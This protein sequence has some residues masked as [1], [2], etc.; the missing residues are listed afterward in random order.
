[1]HASPVRR[2]LKAALASV[3]AIVMGVSAATLVA[4]AA[5]AEAAVVSPMTNAYNSVVNGNYLM[6]GNGVMQAGTSYLTGGTADAFHN[7]VA[8]T[9]LVNDNFQMQRRNAVPALQAAG[10]D[11]STSATLTVPSGASIARAYLFWQ[12]STGLAGNGSGGTVQRCNASVTPDATLAA[13]SPANRQVMLQVGSGAIS[14]VAGAVTIE[15]TPTGTL[16][17]YYSAFADVTSQLS[18]IATGSSQTI[19]VGNLWAAEGRNCYAGWSLALVYDFGRFIPGNDASQA[20]NV[21]IA[22]GHV[23]LG[24]NESQH[25]TF[26]GFTSAAGDIQS[27][28]FLGEGDRN[29][30]G[31]YAQYR[32][33][34][35]GAFTRIAGATGETDNVG[36]GRATGSVRFQGTST[37][38]FFNGSVD[39]RTTALTGIPVGTSSIQLELGTVQDTYML[40]AAALAV[41]VAAVRIEKTFTGSGSTAVDVQDILPG[42]APSYTITVTNAGSSPVSNVQVADTLAPSCV[43]T[44]GTLAVGGVTQYT[45]TG[46]ATNTGL[47]NTATVSGTGIISDSD[48]TVVN[49]GAISLAKTVTPS[50]GYTG[51]PGDTLSY[52]FTIRNSG[53]SELRGVTLTD[54]MSGL[55]GLA[56]DWGTSSVASTPPGTLAAGE[57]VI[58][59]ATYALTVT[60]VDRGTVTNPNA[61]ARGL[62]PNQV[63]VTSTASATQTIPPAP[64]L[65]LSKTGTLAQGA[66]GRVG[67]L[68]T[69]SFSA[70]N[71]GNVTLSGVTITDPH[72]GLS[73]IVY[74]WPGTA[75]VLRA[76]QTV[77]ATATAPI[78]QAE[79]DAGRVVN[80]ARVAGTSPTNVAVNGTATTTVAITQTPTIAIDKNGTL[81]TGAGAAGT[82]VNYTF[83]VVNTGNV[84]LT[85]I[86]VSDPN[87]ASITPPS[88]WT[89]T[90]APGATARFTA[91]HTITQTEV[92]A[93][94]V[95]NT[96]T[97]RGTPP[98]GAA[99]TG[100]D[101]FVQ[102]LANTPGI[103]LEKT[104]AHELNGPGNA[105]DTILYTFA[106]R[107]TGQSTLT[108]ITISDPM[109]AGRQPVAQTWPAATGTLQ[110]GQ[111]ASV[112]YRMPI[113]QA[114][115]DAGYVDNTA[116][117]TGTAQAG[118]VTDSDTHRTPINRTTSVLLSKTVTAPT[119]TPQVGTQLP[120]RFVIAN[121]GSTTLTNVALSDPMFTQA[122]LTYAWPGTP[123]TLAPGAQVVVTASTALTQAQIDAGT[124]GN[125][126]TATA[127]G[128]SGVPSVSSTSHADAAIPRTPALSLTKTGAIAT[129]QVGRVGDTIQYELT[130]VNTGNVTLTNVTASDAMPGLV[131]PTV[132]SWPRSTPGTLLPGDQV[133]FTATYVIRASDVAAGAV[134][135]SASATG[136]GPIGGT[137]IATA[138][139]TVPLPA[140]T[141]VAQPDT[142][143]TTQGAPGRVLPLANDVPGDPGVPLIP[144][145]LTLVDGAGLAVTS[146]TLPGVG[147]FTVDRST[148]GSPAVVFTPVPGFTGQAP[149]VGYRVNDA[150]GTATS[151]TIVATVTPVTPTAQP[152][153][154]TGRQGAPASVD[155]LANDAPGSASIPLQRSSVSYVNGAGQPVATVTVDGQGTWS[156]NR[157]DPQNPRFVFTPLPSFSGT[158]T[159][160][161]YR[162]LDA[163]GT[164]AT[165]TV[166]AQITAVAPALQPDTGSN[167]QGASVTVA[168]FAND[169]PGDPAVPLQP[170]TITLVGADGQGTNT[171]TIAGQGT[172]TLVRTDPAVPRIV[173]TPIAPF[174]GE[175]TPVTYQVSDANGVPARTTFTPTITPVAPI[176]RADVGEARQGATVTIDPFVNDEPG[177]AAVPIVRSQLTLLDAAGNPTDEIV[178]AGQGTWRVVRTDAASP[179]ITFTPLPAFTGQATPQP[180]RIADANGT[181]AR[182]TVGA[183]IGAVVPIASPDTATGRQGA[184]ASVDPLANDRPGDPAVPLVPSTLQLVDGTGTVVP[185]IVV[186]N[187][188]T[189]TVDRTNPDAPRLVFT[190]LPGFTGASTPVAYQVADANGT[191]ASSTVRA[192][193]SAV[194]PIANPDTA[195]GRQGAA[196]PFDVVA[197]DTPG[198]P[199]VPIDRS[200]L[201]LVGAD[202]QGGVTIADQGRYTV[203][204]TNTAAPFVVFTPLLPFTGTATP[205]TYQVADAN[206]TTAQS[207]YTPTLTPVTPVANPDT[208]ATRQGA[209]TTIDPLA[210]DRPGDPAVPL[211]PGSLTLIGAGGQPTDTITVPGQGTWTVDRTG[212]T[213]VVTFTPEPGFSGTADPVTYQVD[214]QNGTPVRSTITVTVA[215]VTPAA[216]PDSASGRQGSQVSAAVLAND[217]AGD[218]AVPLVPSTLTL[219]T[220]AGAPA[221]TVT[222]TGQGTY[223]IDAITDPAAPR[224][225]FT[226]LAS[227]VGTATPVDYRV[228]D[229]NRT[230]ARST[231][232]PTLVGVT[233]VATDDGGAARQGA[234][235]TVLPLANDRPGD[236][237]VPL[238]PATITLLDAAGAAATTVTFDG[239]GTYTLDTTTTP[240]TPRIVFQPVLLFDGDAT[241]VR[242][243][244]TDANGTPATA[245]VRPV[246]A[247]VR[248][249]AAPDAASGLQGSPVSAAVLD[250]DSPG[251]GEVPLVPA[252]L[253][254]LLGDEVVPFVDVTGGRYTIDRGAAGGPRIVFTP[255]ASF[256]G[257]A[258]PV[259]YRVADANT[260]TA[261]STFTP[262]LIGVEP[263]AL[264]DEG[265]GHQGER[266]TLRPLANDSSGDPSVPLVPATFTLLNA[267]GDRVDTLLVPNE[268]LWTTDRTDPL[269]PTVTFAPIGSFT[270]PTTPVR[271]VVADENGTE[272]EAT[273]VV[274]TLTP[275]T[276]V[277]NP[278]A[279]SGR[280]GAPVSAPVVANDAQGHPDVPL[281]PSSL[282]LVDAAGALVPVGGTVTLD[283]TQGT[284]SIDATTDPANPTIV[285]TPVATYANAAE[286]ATRVRYSIAD[287]NGTRAESTFTPTITPVTPVANPDEGTNHQ[288]APVTVSPLAN[289]APGLADV[290]LQPETLTLLDADGNP[291]T[292]VTTTQGR[293][294][295]DTTTEPGVPHIVFTPLLSYVGTALPVT[296]R[297]SDANGTPDTATFTPTLTPVAPTASPDSGTGRQGAPVTIHPLVNDVAGDPAVPLVPTSLTLVG[298][299]GGSVDELVV[300]DQGTWRVDRTTDPANPVIVFEPLPTFRGN[301]TPVP[302]RVSDANGTPVASAISVTI[303]PVDPVLQ[304]DAG[305]A[306]QGATVTLA[307][308]ANDAPGDAGVPLVPSTFT[309]LDAAGNPVAERTVPNEGTYRVDATDPA[310]PL[311][312]FTPL[313]TFR[314]EATPVSYRVADANGTTATSTITPTITGVDPVAQ[315]DA[316]EGRQGA[317]VT[318]DALAN[319]MAGSPEVPLVRPSLTLLDAVGDA[320]DTRVIAGQGTWTVV[321]TDAANPVL[322]FTPELGFVGESTV[323]YAVLDANGTRAP[324]TATATITAVTP[325]ATSDVA[326]SRQGAPA[327]VAPLANDTA[328]DPDVPL[329]PS[330]LTL[331]DGDGNPVAEIVIPG[332]GTYTID[333]STPAAPRIV[334]TPELTFVGPATPAPYRVLDANG[335]PAQSLVLPI[336]EPVTPLANPDAE[337]AR[338]G[339]VITFRP[340]GNDTQGHPDVPFAPATL[341][342]LD[343]DG[344]PVDTL[345]VPGQ[346]TYAVDRSTPSNPT[347]TFTPELSFVGTASPAT[348]RVA[349][350]NGTTTTSTITPTLV[351]V[352]P[353]ANPDA[354]SGRQGSVVSAAVLANDAA[355]TPSV[356]LVPSTLT[357]IDA[358]GNA[359]TTVTVADQGT[360]SID[361]STAS[362]P[363]IA[364]T[365]LATYVGIATPVTYQVADANGTGAR[366]TF[367]PTLVGVT[368]VALDDAGSARQGATVTVLPL[369]NDSAGDASVPLDPSTFMLLDGAGNPVPS[370]TVPLQ[371]VYT[372]AGT[373]TAPQ[374]VFTPFPF[375]T[376]EATPAPYRVADAN[377][378]TATAF[379][380]PTIAGVEPVA[381]PDFASGR[382]GAPVSAAVLDNDSPGE[383]DVPLEP[384]TLTLLQGD[385][386]VATVDVPGG[387]YSIDRTDA[388][389]PRIVF[390]PD[391]AFVGTAE[392]VAYLVEDE[393]GTEA[394][395]TFTPTLVPVTPIADPDAAS[396]RQGAPVSAAV[397]A[398]DDAGHPDVPLDPTTLQLLD[399]S[400]AVATVVEVPGQG[401]Y[402]IDASD[403]DAPRIV[404]TPLPGYVGTA[405]PVT[406]RVADANGT[407]TES[408]FTPTLV[409]VAPIASPDFAS[410][411]QGAAV[412][413]PV[414]ANDDA[415]DDDVPLVPSTLRLLDA[416]GALTTQVDVP[417]QGTY[418]IDVSDADAPRIVFTPLPDFSGQ[419]TAVGYQVS[420]ANGTH[421]QSTFTPT[422]TAVTPIAAPD[423]ATGRQGSPVSSPVLVNDEA[424]DDEV[425]L[426]PATLTL[427]DADGNPVESVTIV[428]EGTY[429]VDASAP[430]SPR[431]VFTPLADYVG[432]AVPVAYRISDAN[433]TPA[434][435]TFTPTLVEVLPIASPDS[436]QA[437]QGKTVTLDA[438][439]NDAAGSADVP[440]V[441]STL[442]LRNGAGE[443]VDELVLDGVGT[444]TVDRTNPDRP[445]LVF[446]P[447]PGYVGTSTVP[448][449]VADAN[450]TLAPTTA[451]ATI[452]AVTPVATD[453][454]S[455]GP[456]GETQTIDP[457]ANDRAGDPSVPLDP[458]TLVLLDESGE[459]VLTR[460]VPGE[461]TY[462]VVDG[463]I[464]FTPEAGFVGTATGV[465]YRVADANGTT[466]Q[467]V[468]TPRVVDGPV[469]EVEDLYGEGMRGTPVTVDP[470]SGEPNLDPTS[471]RLVDASGAQ[472]GAIVVPGEGT[473]TVDPVTGFITFTPEAGL[474]GDPTP[475][476]WIGATTDG[477]IVTG[478]VVVHYLDPVSPPPTVDPTGSTPPTAP[479]PSGP[480]GPGGP[481]LPRTGVEPAGWLLVLAAMLGLVGFGLLRRRR[482]SD[483]L[484]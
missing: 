275:V 304:P 86:T 81:A 480:G 89:G 285:F 187:Q 352:T 49:V 193:I 102:P 278:D 376:G 251:N 403:E 222:I 211:R 450:G 223:S 409:A 206:G 150:N 135:N 228:E 57:T 252:S 484:V 377:G 106:I 9:G 124:V 209:S 69:Y 140:A 118:T 437:L 306:R 208:G 316:G 424:G 400:G 329:V 299:G 143:S 392:P 41:P 248:P 373:A 58:G 204:R 38:T 142:I 157:D 267:A 96:A 225:V 191:I 271:Y 464:A 60:D 334:F 149:A 430:A 365:P 269:N 346:G 463:R 226:P 76:G 390:T 249:A 449:T 18:T 94:R 451:S 219:L 467:A 344:T 363:R 109:L 117:A 321:R 51:R 429:R 391:A 203:D 100:T 402:A 202:A 31:D 310:N 190:P 110:P 221:T 436:G 443:P 474:E 166:T 385:D 273:V 85:G 359:A 22:N 264:P 303:T 371:G 284:Y 239:V 357:L 181:T 261:T 374:V 322:A 240:G 224:I 413:S 380:R 245:F 348:Y 184:P 478:Q 260:E 292:E 19:N 404:F 268:G 389:N 410:G 52:T 183:T 330:T 349:D 75:G 313:L 401:S 335:T 70:T 131:G 397:L 255:D 414:L 281:V 115:I 171:V 215:A 327:S 145:T 177:N 188:G 360:Y 185:Q 305:E 88:G 56:I 394:R 164:A 34:T 432:T 347:V 309:L 107:N 198:D 286:P 105:D 87:V 71:T 23:R 197:N 8:L 132:V 470:S 99:V 42:Q 10:A 72:V 243:R 4:P 43:R 396:G 67:D 263:V 207:T 457:L 433:G 103:D 440:L 156:V 445:V 405:T 353:I 319:D 406:Y 342:L 293:Y 372:V 323:P 30:S 439:A 468:Y 189:W 242:Y 121:N 163:N 237:A 434:E 165:S 230:T 20:R 65:N 79:I 291:A 381:S 53:S 25:T 420:D 152:D 37:D 343:A 326:T 332:Q 129:G 68:V 114:Q 311:V 425:P 270:G 174:T 320:V 173:F 5:P 233:P 232:T 479:A 1:M 476:R 95:S 83:D 259:T 91:S 447:L 398:N 161:P 155:P 11:N 337:S 146:I 141:P 33:G 388:A 101:T 126:A 213:P 170:G 364:F 45:C 453:D 399:G 345:T 74:T 462:V 28:F 272:T 234:P 338:Q 119:G 288:G 473:W 298:A 442:T 90:L 340:L 40:Q 483:E 148:V 112:Q 98:T 36:T 301:A 295:L 356:P 147:T 127:T 168:P 350:A 283:A 78:T 116:S 422:I 369:A 279:A 205:V 431:I 216:V 178:V 158:S 274:V 375:F 50:N 26:S 361:R 84:T 159:A 253:E 367:T 176:A 200:S 133:R 144:S 324:S 231:F 136:R 2:R 454:S 393:N 15:P 417:G 210:N 195:S 160:V 427:L 325:A 46:P 438:L 63:A 7:G 175:A 137:P 378:T 466:A 254:L 423:A 355:G 307:P 241:P 218:P 383:G 122:Q 64:A 59:T 192:T 162:V 104:G 384:G 446:T 199:A 236:P 169:A 47:T 244:V 29:I 341:T 180:Y 395:S 455:V 123:G 48:T 128:P 459:P 412:S 370:I 14:S 289:D 139:V 262:T 418:T 13:G 3:L 407:T 300:E 246:I 296:Y 138:S 182:S 151:S 421:T 266:I 229:A 336:I 12:G 217:S 196:L 6:V 362:A 461:G 328:G 448:Y 167:R 54:P 80:T 387:R 82:L 120:Y 477:T 465:P 238:D 416:A 153:V 194:T 308:L 458:S 297:V 441:G 290:P 55:Q 111:T 452:V 16:P 24:Q 276:P 113:T 35:T 130:I 282:R 125:T 419:A 21:I 220:A 258:D 333:R 314:G 77:T 172:Y 32:A 339:S 471:V 428:G 235:V 154:A 411:R 472:V 92:N 481:D 108:G 408:T 312:V 179:V 426:D 62:N 27:S 331:L 386:R 435:S 287:A 354:A 315:P 44:I 456:V 257:T 17:Q 351:G 294:T 460:T 256:V 73:S 93:G 415:G 379:V 250:N 39:V 382:Q 66:T 186:S 134:T 214:D 280:Q 302:Y 212:T 97:V 277:A 482:R 318:I 358:D 247:G 368:P 61:V 444:W 475:I 265:S 317:V 469:V 201:V 227:Y 366:S